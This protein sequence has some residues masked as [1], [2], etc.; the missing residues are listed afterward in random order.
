MTIA[1][2]TSWSLYSASFTA[3]ATAN[4]GRLEFW[5]GDVA[6]NVWLDGVALSADPPEVDRRDFSNGIVLLNGESTPQT[7]TLEAGFQ[8]FKGTQAPLYQYILDDSDTSFSST[9]S[10]STVVYNTGRLSRDLDPISRPN[11]RMQTAL[12]ITVGRGAAMNWIPVPAKRSGTSIS[13]PT[14][15]TPS[16]FGC[17]RRPTRPAGPRIAVYEIVAGG[18]VVASATIDQTTASAG[19]AWHTVATV[20]LRAADGPFL[21][22]HDGGSGTLIAN[23]V[24]VTSAALYND[25]SAAPQVTLGAFDSI[26]LQRQQP[27]AAP[28]SQVNSIV[29]AASYQPAIASGG[30]VSVV[31]TGFGNSSRSWMSSD[32]SGS[33]LP[34]SLDGVSVTINGKPVYFEYISPTQINAIAPDDD[35]IGQV[36]VQVATPQGTSYAATVLKQK[37]S[38]GFFTYQSGTTTYVAAVHLDGSLVGQ[39][40]TSSRPAVPG[41][42][43]EIYGTDFGP[44]SPATATSQLVSQP[45]PLAWPAAVSVGGVNATVQWAG[46]VSPGLYQLNVTIPMV[47]AG[48]Q[49]VQTTVSGFQ[50][51]LECVLAGQLELT[52]KLLCWRSLNSGGAD[53]LKPHSGRPLT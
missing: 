20:S 51:P 31:G 11:H 3:A 45:A 32:F 1:I 36:P 16:R 4:D 27:A 37:L 17:R 8:R 49:P 18:N 21:R 42:V 12:T 48:D 44:T 6:G 22:V 33:N 23:A 14:A 53:S 7:M 13:R 30:F 24:Y 10:W 38:P 26:L 28:A 46:L 19:D 39:M 43:I 52:R 15:N 5:V 35:T 41:E 2:G 40:G 9:G 25:G 29:N 50:S 47:T 34:V